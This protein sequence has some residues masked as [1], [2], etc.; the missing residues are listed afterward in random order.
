MGGPGLA[1]EREARPKVHVTALSDS[2]SVGGHA[3]P[4]ARIGTW[5]TSQSPR[6]KKSPALVAQPLNP[7]DQPRTLPRNILFLK[8]PVSVEEG[9][10]FICAEGSRLKP[11]SGA[12]TQGLCH[13]VTVYIHT[14]LDRL[15]C[16]AAR[17]AIYS[18]P[19]SVQ[20]RDWPHTP[21]TCFHL[22]PF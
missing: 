5:P 20:D 7:S 10:I 4:V 17:K 15:S 13:R 1:S 6:E 2:E 16:G 12:L 19:G 14:H 21:L 22:V 3:R 8:F 11:S 9:V 18:V